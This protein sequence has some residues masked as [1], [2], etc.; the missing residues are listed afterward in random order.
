MYE[1]IELGY[2]VLAEGATH[3]VANAFTGEIVFSGTRRQC[4]EYILDMEE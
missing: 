1:V 4:W 2:D 3:A